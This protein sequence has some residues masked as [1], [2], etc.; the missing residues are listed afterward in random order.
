MNISADHMDR[1]RDL[2]DY[3][4]AKQVIYRNAG[5]QVVNADDP[6]AATAL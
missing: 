1:Y 2:Q 3:A 6:V 4:A 5:L